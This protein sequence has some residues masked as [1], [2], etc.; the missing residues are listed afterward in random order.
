MLTDRRRAGIVAAS[1]K[2]MCPFGDVDPG[3]SNWAVTSRGK[4]QRPVAAADAAELLNLKE[5]KALLAE[6]EKL[7]CQ[8]QE[9]GL[10]ISTLQRKLEEI[11]LEIGIVREQRIDS[12]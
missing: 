9:Q 8:V 6:V 10:E 4:Q 11:R 7:R 12:S 3:D 2:H 1:S 5:F